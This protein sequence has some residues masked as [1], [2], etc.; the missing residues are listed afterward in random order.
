MVTAN[1]ADLI[2]YSKAFPLESN[3][4]S[5]ST[6]ELDIIFESNRSKQIPICSE[7]KLRIPGDWWIENRSLVFSNQE[8]NHFKLL[9]IKPTSKKTA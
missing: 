8:K 4:N 3:L 9:N 2:F 7:Y 1:N 6:T 5:S